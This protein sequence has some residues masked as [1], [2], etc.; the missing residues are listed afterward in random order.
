M[1]SS[2]LT[3]QRPRVRIPCTT[4]T[5]FSIYKVEII[6][7][8]FELECEKNENKQKEFGIGLVLK[9]D[10]FEGNFIHAIMGS[11]RTERTINFYPKNENQSN[12]AKY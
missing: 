4:S 3:I 10:Y 8:S 9:P 7:L 6:Y 5:L 2:A 12:R 1:E 11:N